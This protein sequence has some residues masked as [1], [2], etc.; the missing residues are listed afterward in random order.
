MQMRVSVIGMKRSKGVLENGNAY[1][2]TKFYVLTKMDDRKGDAKGQ[3]AVEYAYGDSKEYEKFQHLPFPF[4]ADVDIE[5]VTTGT[6]VRQAM[7]SCIPVVDQK[8]TKQ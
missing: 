2:S 3:A 6:T 1:D 7:T 4:Q 8:L 5:V